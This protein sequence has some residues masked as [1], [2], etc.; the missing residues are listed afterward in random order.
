[1]WIYNYYW[2]FWV[3]WFIDGL[4]LRITYVSSIVEIG[5]FFVRTPTHT[6][7]YAYHHMWTCCRCMCT[8]CVHGLFLGYDHALDHRGHVFSLSRGA[9]HFMD[10]PIWHEVGVYVGVGVGRLIWNTHQQILKSV[11]SLI[12]STI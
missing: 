9:R 1:M 7:T 12:A 8:V 2:Y 6:T 3:I 11:G 5:L 10:N 4:F